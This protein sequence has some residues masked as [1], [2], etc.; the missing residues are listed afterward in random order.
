MDFVHDQL[1]DSRKIRALTSVDPFT[2]LAMRI[3]L[4]TR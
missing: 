3:L 1:F 4:S 2:R